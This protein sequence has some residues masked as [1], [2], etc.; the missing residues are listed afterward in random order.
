MPRARNDAERARD[1]AGM[2]AGQRVVEQLLLRLLARIK[3]GKID[4]KGF[5]RH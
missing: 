3:G 4:G 2:A 5:E 1:I